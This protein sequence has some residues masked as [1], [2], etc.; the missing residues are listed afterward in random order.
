MKKNQERSRKIKNSG[1]YE[2]LIP[3][4]DMQNCKKNRGENRGALKRVL[5]LKFSLHSDEI[6]MYR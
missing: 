2:A 1:K 3:C 5:K 6:K 4:E